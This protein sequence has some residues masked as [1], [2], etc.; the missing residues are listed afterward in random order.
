MV[1]YSPLES[2]RGR[3]KELLNKRN[4]PLTPLT[5]PQNMAAGMPQ[6]NF[7]FP[8]PKAQP[9]LIPTN[10]NVY[11]SQIKVALQT[12]QPMPVPDDSVNPFLFKLPESPHDARD[13]H[14]RRHEY[15]AKAAAGGVAPPLLTS[16]QAGV[17]T[18]EFQRHEDDSVRWAAG[19][20]Y[21]IYS[22][23]IEEHKTYLMPTLP[24]GTNKVSN[25]TVLFIKKMKDWRSKW[26]H[27]M[28]TQYVL[29]AVR[30]FTYIFGL[31]Q[32]CQLPDPGRISLW[33]RIFESDPDLIAEQF[34]API[35]DYVDVVGVFWGPQDDLKSRHRAWIKLKF[36]RAVEWTWQYRVN[37]DP[38]KEKIYQGVVF[39][40]WRLLP[41]T[42]EAQ[43]L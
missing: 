24:S 6:P 34:H 42:P 31:T 20:C 3:I 23:I 35:K 25:F 28:L 2:D 41:F 19:H 40:K 36:V 15:D 11:R 14:W 4:V 21:Y 13:R 9:P 12:G 38:S 30:D 17:L 29:E 37:I 7:P 39:R 8:R 5:I 22:K 26:Q 16:G 18:R 27:E 10:I 32:L 43:S 1:P 33:E